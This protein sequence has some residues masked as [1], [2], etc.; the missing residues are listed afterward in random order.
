MAKGTRGKQL[1][2]R[3]KVIVHFGGVLCVCVCTLGKVIFLFV[4]F[5]FL[6]AES[7]DTHDLTNDS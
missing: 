3:Q 1:V 6:S 5:S 4:I 7:L 2:M